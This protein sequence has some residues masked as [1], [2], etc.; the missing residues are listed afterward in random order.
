MI[1]GIGTDIVAVGRIEKA[2]QK[3]GDSF[4]DK[5][6][7]VPEIEYCLGK[8][9][10]AQHLAGR[11]AAKEAVL[12][13]L[14][15]G[16]SQGISWQEIEVSSDGGPCVAALSGQAKT[17][18]QKFNIVKIFISISHEKEYASAMCVMERD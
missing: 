13:A 7:T 4:L 16:L 8:T 18:A 3:H 9:N 6:L 10:Q 17:I 2:W 11:F 1:H 5:I 14:G 12:K 15:T